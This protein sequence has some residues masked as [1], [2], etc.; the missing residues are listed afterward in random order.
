MKKILICLT[1]ISV[2]VFIANLSIAQV[3]NDIYN[4]YYQE[5]TTANNSYG[6]STEFETKHISSDYGKRYLLPGQG[7]RWHRGV[8]FAI[9][10]TPT[11][12]WDHFTSINTGTIK[13]INGS[14]GYKYIITEGTQ[15]DSLH[16]FGY[17]HL[18]EQ[19]QPNPSYKR[20]DLVLIKMDSVLNQ[21][22]IID[23]S[24]TEERA[25]GQ[26]TGTATYNFNGTDSIWDVTTDINQ[27]DVLGNIGRSKGT[28]N[29]GYMHVHVY[30]FKNINI[31]L[32]NQGQ[33]L[34]DNIHND[35]DPLQF[36]SHVNTEYHTELM[37]N[38]AVIN[39]GNIIN[40][41]GANAI[42]IR[43]R[44]TM[45]NATRDVDRFT[46]VVMDIDDVDI[47]IKK[48]YHPDENHSQWGNNSSN[49]QLIMGEHIESHFSLG[50]RMTSKIYPVTA[51]YGQQ[52][53]PPNNSL[54][55][56]VGN[57]YGDFANTGID[58]YAYKSSTGSVINNRAYDDY[59]FSDFYTRVINS[60]TLGEDFE[61][62]D[63]ND[64]AKYKDGIYQL[65]AKVTTVRGDEYTSMECMAQPPEI[66]IDNFRPYI[67]KVKIT[68]DWPG[69]NEPVT[70]YEYEWAWNPN[71][72]QLN[73]VPVKNIEGL[74]GLPFNIEIESS[75]I[76]K[77]CKLE[78]SSLGI[79]KT[80]GTQDEENPY[81][82]NFQ[83]L[84]NPVMG[85][86]TLSI[87][88]HD[89]A[90]N[91]LQ[92]EPEEIPIRQAPN[93]D[94]DN[95]EPE[96]NPGPDE[97][98][99]INFA[100]Y[101]LAFT[102]EPEIIE[103]GV[104][105]EVYIVNNSSG[106][107]GDNYLWYWFF[108]GET[109]PTYFEGRNPPSV[110]YSDYNL[111][112]TKHIGVIIFDG[113]QSIAELTKDIQI[114]DPAT[115]LLVDF[116]AEGT[117]DND[118]LYGNSPLTI[119]FTDASSGIP[120]EW[121]WDFG[122]YWGESTDQNPTYTFENNTGSPQQYTVSLQACN[123]DDCAVE[124]KEALITVYP[125]SAPLDPW[126]NFSYSKTSLFA[127]STVTFTNTSTGEIDTY[128]WDLDGNGSFETNL[129]NP[130]TLPYGVSDY[131]ISLKVTNTDTQK[132]DI[133]SRHLKIYEAPNSGYT[134]DF[135]W[136]P[137]PA[138]QGNLIHFDE[139]VTGFYASYN[140]KWIVYDPSGFKVYDA[141]IQNPYLNLYETGSYSV[142]LEVYDFYDTFLGVC[143][144]QVNI[145]PPALVA[146]PGEIVPDDISYMAGFGH[147]VSI[148]ENFAVV[149]ANAFEH[150]GERTGAIYIY[151]FHHESQT[152]SKK[153]GPLVP[154]DVKWGDNYACAVGISGNYIVV[155]AERQTN[156]PSHERA[157]AVYVYHYNGSTWNLMPD[158]LIP[159]DATYNDNCGW[160]LSIDGNYLV[161]GTSG[162]TVFPDPDS[163]GYNGSKDHQGKAYIYKL[164][165]NTW[166][167]KC[168]IFDENVF[169]KDG[170]GK[171]V[172]ISGTRI[173]VG[174]DHDKAFV[175]DRVTDDVWEQSTIDLA[176]NSN[177]EIVVSVSNN[178]LLIGDHTECYGSPSVS[179]GGRAYIFEF[180][181]GQWDMEI[182]LPHIVQRRAHFGFSV[183]INGRYAVVGV[184]GEDVFGEY[185]H[186]GATYIYR[187]NFND[188]W[189]LAEKVTPEYYSNVSYECTQYGASVHCGNQSIIV[190]RP[191][192]FLTFPCGTPENFPGTVTIFSNYIYPC[193]RIISED[194]YHPSPNTYPEQ[195]AGYITLGGNPPGEVYFQEGVDIAYLGGDILLQDGF[196]A[197]EGCS[198]LA[199]GMACAYQPP[200]K[201]Q[202]IYTGSNDVE[203]V[204]EMVDEIILN[205]DEIINEGRE[206]KLYPNPTSGTITIE[207]IN[208]NSEISAYNSFGKQ[209]YFDNNF[210]HSFINLSPYPK[211]IYLLTIKTSEGV[212]TEK[213][214]LQ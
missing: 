214:V 172:S 108:S 113:G 160:S 145:N 148:D 188:F 101:D 74:I 187:K 184:P 14:A 70:F 131:D 57:T 203:I 37:V 132:S 190:G 115:Y 158:K 82:W 156:D 167:E 11:Y 199:K 147:S 202:S 129:E 13:K 159:G 123:P 127:P 196:T 86:H 69:T 139:D 137:N 200:L 78:I 168:K 205:A 144:K 90:N 87:T 178:A 1:I 107:E 171:S 195:S 51:Q 20:G 81:L 26:V 23:L 155:G 185:S 77:D 2:H 44:G 43:V 181:N 97:K 54:I 151:E 177:D 209:V 162:G 138:T 22:A 186:S 182:D 80:P 8:D 166:V 15:P 128:E 31:A 192:E 62:A 153:Q 109:S 194:D 79:G 42:S 98:H 67:A 55:N 24:S 135:S 83:V 61:F 161:V 12:Q 19:A 63:I 56:L 40:S 142:T 120:I 176:G 146:A 66:I 58:P 88:G 111:P 84:G 93:N 73:G 60:D 104:E 121:L 72:G 134:V 212:F 165:N 49:Y 28:G 143:S 52:A 112:G 119:N 4:F 38:P 47:Y 64:S 33:G 3:Q 210:N 27:G 163:I 68:Q 154:A 193:D 126:A 94:S 5:H 114:I 18:F 91:E 10:G 174:S 25:F 85:P 48:S 122:D 96:P 198:F 16:H 76:L 103:A 116:E 32:G 65:F 36:I 140:C 110:T 41:S 100:S 6:N 175:F 204:A 92:T 206:I 34:F 208:A 157:G 169:V 117:I 191:G 125:Q 173:A 30:L 189:N 201:T 179:R 95:W 133:F 29:Y 53:N 89:M 106:Y 180:D 105:T 141:F 71:L 152:W 7:T 75:E 50:A 164:E 99:T 130:G 46:N 197:A 183:S 124:M 9:K 136:D 21:Y 211:G 59:Y 170:F 150:N 39:S 213:V 149:A 102:F 45:I 35:H 17:G 207:G 118:E